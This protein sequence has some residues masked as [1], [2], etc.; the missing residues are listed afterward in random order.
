MIRAAERL[1]REGLGVATI[2]RR[3]T[4]GFDV[5]FP[6]D[7]PLPSPERVQAALADAE[8]RIEVRATYEE[9]VLDG[10]RRRTRERVWLGARGVG[11][12]G[13]PIEFAPDE[14]GF[15][16]F[17]AAELAR[18][19]RARERAERYVPLDR[20]YRLVPRESSRPGG[21]PNSVAEFAV[22]EEPQRD[23]HRFG[24]AV[25]TNVRVEPD[26]N[27]IPGVHYDVKTDFRKD[28]GDW[29]EANV[30]LP[31]AIVVGGRVHSAPRIN[32]RLVDSV[33]ISMGGAP[34]A[35][36]HRLNEEKASRMVGLLTSLPLRA[37]FVRV[38]P[39]APSPGK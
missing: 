10:G 16:A 2:A 32:D 34:A 25:L 3:G 20:R 4:T 9:L 14:A 30:G 28:F 33:V 37:V 8:L 7:A 26:A 36:I 23:E 13:K 5:I 29:T 12:D 6:L 39:S 24:G 19:S 1:R 35:V 17:K 27:G 22:L 18:W 21:E 11:P 15:D 31:M 38:R